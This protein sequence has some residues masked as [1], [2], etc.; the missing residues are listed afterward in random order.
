MIKDPVK[1]LAEKRPTGVIEHCL[2]KS[3][4]GLVMHAAWPFLRCSLTLGCFKQSFVSG[5]PA[6]KVS[7]L[8]SVVASCKPTI[9]TLRLNGPQPP[10]LQHPPSLSDFFQ[11]HVALSPS[12][13]SFDSMRPLD[14]PAA[15]QR[16]FGTEILDQM[17]A[18][19]S[20]VLMPLHIV[21]P[22]HM[23]GQK[24]AHPMQFGP[25]LSWNVSTGL[26][27]GLLSKI[28]FRMLR[29]SAATAH[30]LTNNHV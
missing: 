13:E 26:Q 1:P 22:L 25:E 27:L 12:P 2:L 6:P 3:S 24:S 5:A 28:T 21:S 11:V 9:P 23:D 14:F 29:L 19:E 18:T 17:L 10:E 7:G 20:L 15:R 16:P 8:K 4:T 30:S